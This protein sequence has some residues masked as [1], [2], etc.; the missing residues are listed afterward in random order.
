MMREQANMR[1][2]GQAPRAF[3]VSSSF[4][5]KPMSLDHGVANNAGEYQIA[6]MTI[7]ATAARRTAR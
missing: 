5:L 4:L 1:S 7:E 2:Q 6:P 3:M